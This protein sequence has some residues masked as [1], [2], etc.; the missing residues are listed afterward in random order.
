MVWHE[1]MDAYTEG[2]S[3]FTG[4]AGEHWLL[5]DRPHDSGSANARERTWEDYQYIDWYI[6]T[7]CPLN[8]S[9]I[10]VLQ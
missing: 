8:S 6:T 1:T 4:F 2:G 5:F 9:V 7:R 10:Y 3:G